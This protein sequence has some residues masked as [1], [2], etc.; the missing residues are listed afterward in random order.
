[1]R[2]KITKK[3]QKKKLKKLKLKI[4]K[5]MKKVKSNKMD[6]RIAFVFN[7]NILQLKMG[8]HLLR[9]IINSRNYQTVACKYF[10]NVPCHVSICS[11]FF[12]YF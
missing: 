8:Q 2:F 4:V 12:L 7:L 5:K 1:M 10:C 6:E 9:S 11:L 3:R